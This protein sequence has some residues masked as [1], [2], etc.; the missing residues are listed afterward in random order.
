MS[1]PVVELSD[2][3]KDDLQ[4]LAYRRIIEAYKQIAVAGGSHAHSCLLAHLGVELPLEL[5]PWKLLQRHIMSDYLNHNGHE[6]ILR[7]LYRLYGEA[8]E[9]RD[10]FSST[11]ATSTYDVFLLTVAETL[12]DSFPASGK[13]LS[14]L[15]S[16]VPYLP[17]SA[18]KLLEHLCSPGN[19]GKVEEFQSGDR[20]TQGL[21]TVWNLILL[22]PPI[23]DSCLKIA[24]QSVVHQL[25]EVRMK[26][27][28]LIA[29]KLYPMSSIAQQ[30]ED[31]AKEML[32]LVTNIV[33]STDVMNAEVSTTEPEK[34]LNLE[35]QLSENSLACSAAK[36]ITSDNQ[37]TYTSQNMSSSLLHEAQR[38]MS[39][40]FALC[41]K[42]HS[43]LRQI[44]V[45]YK[46]ASK[47]VKH[48]IHHQIPILVRTVGSSPVLL[49]IISDP[50][51]GSENLLMQVS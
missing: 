25:E 13:T 7:V 26:A 51:N 4:M 20:I 14:R 15:L 30:I 18:L 47:T 21:S 39:F 5:D 40:Y 19:S 17:K 41:T 49:E 12:R 43:L 48:A 27:I 38:C 45:I 9:E 33:D 29:N 42:K 37:Q 16:E 24:V 32:L 36:D 46:S 23:R 50:P 35:R 3:Q 44:F 1:A 28:R 8:E 34:D 22:R 10:F 31:F 2:E 11:T 6:L